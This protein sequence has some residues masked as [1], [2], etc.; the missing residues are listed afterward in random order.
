MHWLKYRI[1]IA[2]QLYGVNKENIMQANWE[3]RLL[4]LAGDIPNPSTRPLFSYWAGDAALEKAYETCTQITR[5]HSKSFHMASSSLPEEK[6]S[7]TRALYAFCR[8]VDD[9]VDESTIT[10]EK[11]LTKLDYW[12]KTVLSSLACESDLVAR[13]WIDT[14]NRYHIPRLYAI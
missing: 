6:R 1:F 13:A 5:Q 10:A 2:S 3:H 7:A 12:K 14:L 4:D 8:M 9:I 11:R